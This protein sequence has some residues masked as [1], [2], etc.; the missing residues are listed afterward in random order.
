MAPV[1]QLI[2]IMLEP[3]SLYPITWPDFRR[4]LQG[5]L[6]AESK[7]CTRS[8]V[9]CLCGGNKAVSGVAHL[10]AA[11]VKTKNSISPMLRMRLL[12]VPVPDLNSFSVKV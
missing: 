6:L 4:A 5:E 12:R 9:T 11:R 1:Q 3:S 8:D 2:M 7:L 10:P